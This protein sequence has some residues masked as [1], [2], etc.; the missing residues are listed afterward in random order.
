MKANAT[1]WFIRG[2]KETTLLL[3]VN[4]DLSCGLM[5]LRCRWEIERGWGR[6]FVPSF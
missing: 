6:F 5:M 1:F 2:G 4:K 3:K